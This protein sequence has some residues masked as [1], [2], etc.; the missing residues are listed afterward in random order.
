[1]QETQVWP[2]GG[3]E[4]L[5]KEM[6]GNPLQYSCLENPMDRGACPSKFGKPQNDYQTSFLKKYQNQYHLKVSN[7]TELNINLSL[8]NFWPYN[9]RLCPPN[10]TMLFINSINIYWDCTI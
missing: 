4:P 6:N 9:I 7:W 8:H 10:L 5:E 3:K 1:M 2:L